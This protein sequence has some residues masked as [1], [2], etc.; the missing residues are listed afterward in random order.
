MDLACLRRSTIRALL[1]K[2][3]SRCLAPR[4]HTVPPLSRAC[5]R[6]LR[7]AAKPDTPGDRTAER[8]PAQ[9]PH[10]SFVF[11]EFQNTQGE[12]DSGTIPAGLGEVTGKNNRHVFSGVSRPPRPT[13]SEQVVPFRSIN[14]M[15]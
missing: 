9:E 15:C 3:G 2:N 13:P 12:R 4:V 8:G 14:L 10:R 7:R 5:L 6:N 11:P 1:R